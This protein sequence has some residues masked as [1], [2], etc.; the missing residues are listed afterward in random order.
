MRMMLDSQLTDIEFA[1]DDNGD[2]IYKGTFFTEAEHVFRMDWWTGRRYRIQFGAKPEEWD[3][4]PVDAGNAYWNYSHTDRQLG[5][6]DK[7]S[8]F[9]EGGHFEGTMIEAIDPFTQEVQGNIRKKKLRGLSMEIQPG[10]MHLVERNKDKGDLFRSVGQRFDGLASL[11]RP[12]F[13][14]SGMDFGGPNVPVEAKK[15]VLQSLLNSAYAEAGEEP[16]DDGQLIV[17]TMTFTPEQMAQI[18]YEYSRR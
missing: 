11:M 8:F 13:R 3:L 2:T 7:V 5:N 14:L 15:V 6:V 9:D 1:E 4:S 16:P 12:A 17:P 18:I 10:T